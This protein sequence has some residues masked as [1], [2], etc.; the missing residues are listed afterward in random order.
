[1]KDSTTNEKNKQL[2][3][4]ILKN[5]GETSI[6]ELLKLLYLIDLKYLKDKN[7]KLTDFNYVR[8][9]YGP[10]DKNIYWIIESL[11]SE[12][13][14]EY[15]LYNTSFW[16]EITKY[17]ILN[18]TMNLDIETELDLSIAHQLLVDFSGF[19][20]SDL[21]KIA[22]KTTPMLALWAEIGNTKGFNQE[23]LP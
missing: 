5:R 12:G 8:Y 20:A 13:K 3:L 17:S 15:K 7:Q 1:M 21:T 18:T 4:F 2:V 19:T 16:D 9:N 10:F 23:L 6:T 22:Y 11:I 14:I